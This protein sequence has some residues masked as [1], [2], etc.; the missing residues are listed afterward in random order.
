MCTSAVSDPVRKHRR[1][2]GKALAG[3]SVSLLVVGLGPVPS[4]C[5]R[6]RLVQAGV[7]CDATIASAKEVFFSGHESQ[8]FVVHDDDTVVCTAS[9]TVHSTRAGEW[10]DKVM[11]FPPSRCVDSRAYDVLT[12]NAFIRLP[13]QQ[14]SLNSAHR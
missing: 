6:S 1:V 7:A 13:R 5:A 11:E 12:S 8:L 14:L 10:A 9:T 2:D 4:E 3:S